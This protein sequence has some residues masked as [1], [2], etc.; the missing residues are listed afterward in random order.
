MK[1]IKRIVLLAG[2]DFMLLCMLLFGNYKVM[3]ESSIIETRSSLTAEDQETEYKGRIALTF[4]DGPHPYY[5]EQLL[6]GLKKRGVKATFFVMGKQAEEYPD[7]IKRMAE[8]GHLIGNHTYTH[9][10]LCRTN[11]EA[12]KKEL[13]RTNQLIFELTGNN[14]EFVRPPFGAW[15]K[16][17]EEELNMFPVMWSVEAIELKTGGKI[18]LSKVFLHTLTTTYV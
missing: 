5:T 4:D 13:D 3:Q 12:F 6:D 14:T 10:Q 8:E 7:I 11:E 16:K 9:L 15:N 17:F 18:S 2:V 1:Y